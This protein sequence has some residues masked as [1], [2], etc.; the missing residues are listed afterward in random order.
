MREVNLKEVKHCWLVDNLSERT[1]VTRPQ[2]E[3]ES[4]LAW[5]EII[6]TTCN[7]RTF[8][9]FVSHV[10]KTFT[11][12]GPTAHVWYEVIPQICLLRDNSYL[13]HA[14]LTVSAAYRFSQHPYDLE[15]QQQSIEHYGK[16][17]STLRTMD[18][19]AR[20]MN[21]AAILASILLLCSYEVRL[22]LIKISNV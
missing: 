9:Y 17:L 6:P 11:L 12:S 1:I 18:L 15:S 10:S 13:F 14:L 5:A 20:E 21:A 2:S 22:S 8:Q 7:S 4:K 16:C 19:N 3:L